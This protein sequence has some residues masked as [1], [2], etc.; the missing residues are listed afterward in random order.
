MSV[1]KILL[2]A[3]F[4]GIALWFLSPSRTIT[5]SEPGVVEISYLGQSGADAAAVTDAFRIFE[6]ESRAAHERDPSHP[7]YRIVTGQNASGDQTAD[8]TRFLVSVA[9]GMPPD[10]IRFDRY[11]ITEWAARGAFAKLDD[12]VAGDANIADPAAVR[13]ENF[14]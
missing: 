12:F 9:G 3:L 10:L 8:P 14:Y 1:W 7:I 4:L 5:P 6:A 13:P 2:F 11:A